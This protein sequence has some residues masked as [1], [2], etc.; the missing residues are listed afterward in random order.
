MAFYCY[1]KHK[2]QMRGDPGELTYKQ[3]PCGFVELIPGARP[4]PEDSGVGS[5]SGLGDGI[6]H[7]QYALLVIGTLILMLVTMN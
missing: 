7:G 2:F 4:I 3:C 5:G 6:S 1:G